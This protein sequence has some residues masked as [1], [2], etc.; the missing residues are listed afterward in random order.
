MS[1][2]RIIILLS[3]SSSG[4]LAA[5][6]LPPPASHRLPSSN[7]SDAPC[8]HALAAGRKRRE[9]DRFGC[10]EPTLPRR[11]VQRGAS[12]APPTTE[13]TLRRTEPGASEESARQANDVGRETRL[14]VP[15][16]SEL[17]KLR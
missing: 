13:S 16:L 4:S 12:S 15:T 5:S 14:A 8:R 17:Q 7:K 9:S 2:E 10:A 11:P 1:T 6:H 3:S